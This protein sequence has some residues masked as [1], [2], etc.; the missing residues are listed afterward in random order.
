MSGLSSN[1]QAGTK[2]LEAKNY[3]AKGD[4]HA[5]FAAFSHS[6][7]FLDHQISQHHGNA[8]SKYLSRATSI[9]VQQ[10]N[11]EL[12]RMSKYFKEHHY[13]ALALDSSAS[14]GAV[15]KAYRN[16]ARK[17]HPDKTNGATN[18]LFML[19]KSS[20]DVLSDSK[21]RARYDAS[22]ESSARAQARSKVRARATS[23][24][25][26][27]SAKNSARKQKEA[28]NH[29]ARELK[30]A[31]KFVKMQQAQYEANQEKE[32]L[33]KFAQ[34]KA[35]EKA[36]VRAESRR[37]SREQAEARAAAR[38]TST[39]DVTEDI[40]N[41]RDRV[42]NKLNGINRGTE[43]EVKSD[44]AKKKNVIHSSYEGSNEF[45]GEIFGDKKKQ[46]QA[47]K[48]MYD[49]SREKPFSSRESQR[50][51]DDG[52]R[53]RPVEE[54]A[55]SPDKGKRKKVNETKRP[56]P[57]I[58]DDGIRVRAAEEDPYEKIEL[59]R[60]KKSVFNKKNEE[61]MNKHNIPPPVGI[62][63]KETKPEKTKPSMEM[64][65]ESTEKPPSVKSEFVPVPPTKKKRSAGSQ[66]LHRYAVLHTN[67]D[68]AS[69]IKNTTKQPSTK[70]SSTQEEK[71]LPPVA[72]PASHGGSDLGSARKLGYQEK[73]FVE[74][75]RRMW[76]DAVTEAVGAGTD[77]KFLQRIVREE[78]EENRKYMSKTKFPKEKRT[79]DLNHVPKKSQ[80][81]QQQ[82]PTE[83]FPC[84]NCNQDVDL[85]NV[86]EHTKICQARKIQKKETNSEVAP[87]RKV[88]PEPP[89][90][91]KTFAGSD[92]F[93]CQMCNSNVSLSN[94]MDHAASCIGSSQP[95]GMFWGKSSAG[96]SS[97][98]RNSTQQSEHGDFELG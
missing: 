35:E 63:A 48:K 78:E 21:S 59:Q 74:E 69:K 13:E 93:K 58:F 25:N 90:T 45:F 88:T 27:N 71:T 19:I 14:S 73:D 28:Q 11:D 67:K 37:A 61:K 51:F 57:K 79:G 20:Y 47:K 76:R 53:V 6:K 64:R 83:T 98:A 33:R 86:I 42:M 49:R 56:A 65:P 55:Y 29:I 24:P 91:T 89:S 54:G 70:G 82:L 68:A 23:R 84:K 95:Q 3:L 15:K 81:E 9:E 5:A 16:L 22:V 7:A 4:V 40:N 87:E 62:K 12:A 8:A 46:Q 38:H 26:K 44:D 18:E 66:K 96:P 10:V 2:W 52:I 75:V 72:V 77:A 30:R 36:K 80:L 50:I 92:F 97:T 34:Q 85:R 43:K 32:R 41:I 39:R 17:Y 94:A 60:K 31:W 1:A